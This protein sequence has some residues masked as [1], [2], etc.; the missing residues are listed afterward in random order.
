MRLLCYCWLHGSIPADPAQIARLI[1]KG[2]STTLATTLATMFQPAG[3]N[4]M[5]HDRLEAERRK[6]SDWRQKSSNG[7][8][9]SAQTRQK[10]REQ[11]VGVQ[12]KSEG[13]LENGSNQKATLQSS[14]FSLPSSDNTN[15]AAPAVPKKRNEL[16]DALASVDGADVRQIPKTAWSGIAKCI[17]ELKEVCPALTAA[18][19]QRR[20]VNYRLHYPG[21]LSPHALAK[22]WAKCD[23]PPVQGELSMPA[24]VN[25]AE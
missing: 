22:H 10:R 7:G 24:R 20:A 21:T 2:A 16:M 9:K 19:I 15:T 5:T 25:I 1:G 14:V 4:R 8:K 17:A 13:S 6:Q 23:R 18:E 12:Q 11:H 3:S